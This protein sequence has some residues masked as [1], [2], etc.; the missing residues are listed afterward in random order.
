M[1]NLIP[2]TKTD[3]RSNCNDPTCFTIKPFIYIIIIKQVF[4]IYVNEYPIFVFLVMN[5]K[6][7]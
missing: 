6:Q 4:H 5:Q 3:Q 1:E 2:P 7:R